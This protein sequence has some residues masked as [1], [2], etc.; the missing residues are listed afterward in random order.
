MVHGQ[1]KIELYNPNTKVKNVVRSE[2]TF[3]GSVI[4]MGTRNLGAGNASYMTN[5]EVRANPIW[6]EVV[7]GIMLFR[8]TIQEGKHYMPA[9]N[10]MIGNG[11][12]DVLNSG[13]PNELG[14]WNATESSS[15]VSSL[16]MVYDFA[17]Q[18]ANG[19]ISCVCLTS[20]TGGNAGYGNASGQIKPENRWHLNYRQDLMQINVRHSHDW[21]KRTMRGNMMYRFESDMTNLKVKVYKTKC[22]VTQATVFDDIES[23]PVE[24]D[25]S[26]LHYA[27]VMTE[28]DF[29]ASCDGSTGKIFLFKSAALDIV[30][31]GNYYYWEYDP[32]NDTIAER[33][34]VNPL[35]STLSFGLVNIAREMLSFKS[36]SNLEIF[37]V[38]TGI[39]I[40]EYSI[41]NN[42]YGAT[43]MYTLNVMPEGLCGVPADNARMFI[44]DRSQD[45]MLPTNTMPNQSS[46]WLSPMQYQLEDDF[47]CYNDRYAFLAHNNPLYL[48]TINNLQSPVTKTAA[49]TMKV[50]Y[51]LTEA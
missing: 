12:V 10:R 42:Q 7:G 5:G 50:T 36:G 14:S 2:N 13:N 30:S 34:F 47:M 29:Y 4:A 51:T 20:R 19:N 48:A 31:G 6:H 35:S 40:G 3:Q 23:L 9:G 39:H 43:Q 24:I 25:V 41:F 26:N 37:D 44:Y 21:G 15:G 45:T 32:S 8:D 17:T 33:T 46:Y 16:T 22:H 38:N 49:Q 18:Q 28:N 11:A 1:T 27:F